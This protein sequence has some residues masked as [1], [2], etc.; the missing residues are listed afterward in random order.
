METFMDLLTKLISYI[1]ELIKLIVDTVQ[2]LVQLIK[3]FIQTIMDTIVKNLIEAVSNVI[4]N[5]LT[6][7]VFG[8]TFSVKGNKTNAQNQSADGDLLWVSTKGSVFSID[9]N[10]TLKFAR[11]HKEDDEKPYYDI[12]LDSN[13]KVGD[14]VLEITVDPMMAIQSYIIEGHGKSEAEKGGGW[15]IDFYS[16]EIEEYKE[17][18]YCLS[19][20]MKGMNSIPIPFLGL[21]ATVDCGFIIHYNATK[22]TSVVINE[23]ELN[24]EGNDYDNEWFEIYDPEGIVGDDWKI[25]SHSKGLRKVP[26]SSLGSVNE[27]VYTVYNLSGEVLHN[28]NR[29]EP[30]TPGDGLIL[31]DGDGHVIDKTPKFKDPGKGDNKTWQRG[32]DGGAIWKLKEETKLG[33]NGPEK[34]DMKLEIMDALKS[35]FQVAWADFIEKDL[36]IDAIIELIQDW[37]HNFIEMVLTLIQDAVHRVFVY[38]DLALEDAT[39]SAGGGFRLS[40]GMDGDG[41]VILLRWIIDTIKT[42]IYNL[43]NPGNCEDIPTIPK[44]LP[45]HMFIRFELYFSVG[46]PKLITKVCKDPPPKC[47]F[48]IAIQANIPALV[49]LLG[50][51]WGDWEVVFGVYLDHFPSRALSKTFGTSED[52]DSFVDLWLFRVRVYEIS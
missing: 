20:V 36:S 23:F 15:G 10:F 41:V 45:E 42:F 5:G 2:F 7:S 16:P 33:E 13:F 52:K 12:L 28:G 37:I 17:V 14:F 49:N 27:D 50:W 24:P 35:S 21:K 29:T 4:E 1:A 48:A 46:T 38:I 25:S 19:D 43:M 39:G 9:I 8:W 34:L 30:L 44:E 32:Y 47:R 26:L 40:L 6:I 51:D 22:G 11:Y 18:K 3:D 31:Y